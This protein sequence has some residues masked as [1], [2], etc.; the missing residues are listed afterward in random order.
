MASRA[1]NGVWALVK[2]SHGCMWAGGDLNRGSWV[3]GGYQWLG[4]FGRFCP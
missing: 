2:D 3:D 1:G 4:G